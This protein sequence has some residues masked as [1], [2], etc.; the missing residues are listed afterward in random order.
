MALTANIEK[1]PKN[2]PPQIVMKMWTGRIAST[3]AHGINTGLSDS[4]G[5]LDP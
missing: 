5:M 4:T 1:P 3:T 2:P